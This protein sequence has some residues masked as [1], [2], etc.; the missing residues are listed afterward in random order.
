[1][2]SVQLA[3]LIVLILVFALLYAILEWIMFTHVLWPHSYRLTMFAI[4]LYVSVLAVCATFHTFN[5]YTPIIV[6][7]TLVTMLV[8]E[9]VLEIAI[10]HHKLGFWGYKW[11]LDTL[12]WLIK[13]ILRVM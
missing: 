7:L 4:F 2:R 10:H 3:K 11:F 8:I 13:Q 12:N 5:H 6:L 9:D 1:M